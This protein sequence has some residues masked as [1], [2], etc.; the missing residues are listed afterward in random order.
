MKRERRRKRGSEARRCYDC[1][2]RLKASTTAGSNCRPGAAL[3]SSSASARADRVA[4]D[5]RPRHRVVGVG[6]RNDARAERDLRG[7]AAVRIAEAVHPLVRVADELRGGRPGTALSRIRSAPI[8]GCRRISACSSARQRRRLAQDR[9]RHGE[10][11]EIVQQ[12]GALDR[13]DLTRREAAAH[14]RR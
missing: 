10:L 6:D 13:G 2:T 7:V 14:A 4:E 9:F 1:A 5:A 12:R 3:S 11:A 8:S